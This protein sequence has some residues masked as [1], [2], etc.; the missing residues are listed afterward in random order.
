MAFKGFGKQALPFFKA[1]AFHQ[2][3]DWFEANR[4]IYENEVKEPFG[5]LIDDLSTELGKKKL[6]LYGDRRKAV[7]RIHRDVRFSKDK[8]PYKTNAG[9]V[10]HR[11]GDKNAGGMLYVHIDPEGCFAAAGWWHP[12]KETIARFRAAIAK[13]PKAWFTLEDA[14]AKAKLKM[15]DEYSLKRTPKGFEDLTDPRAVA[16]IR[17]IGY[18]VSRPLKDSELGSA[19]L[20]KSILA[21]AE[22]AEPL[23]RYGWKLGG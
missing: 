11:N 8:S 14:L 3:K 2:T 5:D 13:S 17:R 15:S 9:A 19:K 6:P 21:F 23:L 10:L 18:V 22:D 16:A 12:E 20:V 1:L 7:F 4:A